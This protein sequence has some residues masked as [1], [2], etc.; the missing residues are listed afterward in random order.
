MRL[1][2][3]TKPHQLSSIARLPVAAIVLLASSCSS[4][5]GAGGTYV[6]AA[7]GAGLLEDAEVIRDD[8]GVTEGE[9]SFD[10]GIA[11]LVAVGYRID[12]RWS[13]ELEYAFRE[14]SVSSVDGPGGAPAT[15]GDFASTALMLN[16]LYE[17][18]TDWALDPYV[19][20]GFGIA[21]EVDIDLDGPGFTNG[22]S[23]STETP[24]AQFMLGGRRALSDDLSL[25]VEGRFFRAFDPDMGS[26]GGSGRV[27]SE[28]GHTALLLG[29]SYGF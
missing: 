21:T 26:E 25:F 27:E 29:A 22:R 6:K 3:R 15:G 19:G 28:Y 7:L 24:A 1:L 23:F 11:A 16:A 18:D 5:G 13:V 2:L 12:E 4:V 20:L 10:G 14:N 8:G 9:G 17:F